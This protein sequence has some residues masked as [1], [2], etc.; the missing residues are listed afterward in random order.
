MVYWGL[1]CVFIYD[2]CVFGPCGHFMPLIPVLQCHFNML[3]P[4]WHIV[5][6]YFELM[7]N[8]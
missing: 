2:T 7:K 8:K 5:F 6:D 1:K 4:L 3:A